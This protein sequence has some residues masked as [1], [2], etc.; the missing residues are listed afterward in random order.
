MLVSFF[1]FSVTLKTFSFDLFSELGASSSGLLG[2]SALLGKSS[3]S[4]LFSLVGT[5]ELFPDSTLTVPSDPSSECW[6]SSSCTSF[7]FSTSC[8]DAL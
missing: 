3:E 4:L 8:G 6:F 1:E 2:V 7:S 5:C